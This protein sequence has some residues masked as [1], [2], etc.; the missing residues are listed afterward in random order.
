MKESLR[1]EVHSIGRVEIPFEDVFA[2]ELEML[3]NSRGLQGY[4]YIV[5]KGS[6][7]LG[8][9]LVE[10]T[11][12]EAINRGLFVDISHRG[13][14]VADLLLNSLHKT[15]V[16]KFIWTNI[17]KGSERVYRKHGYKII[18]FRQELNQSIGY[19][20]NGKATGPNIE[21]LMKKIDKQLI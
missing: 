18:G 5:Y 12:T 15:Q 13:R 20:T 3:W 16:G 14:G 17:T 4:Q 11:P 9:L 10:L 21:K 19:Y 6:Q 8:F 7:P 2:K 1:L